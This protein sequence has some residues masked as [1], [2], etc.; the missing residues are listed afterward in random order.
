MRVGTFDW[1]DKDLPVYLKCT[2]K[3][4]S[5]LEHDYITCYEA[6]D[7]AEKHEICVELS[8]HPTYLLSIILNTLR[9]IG[10]L[11]VDYYGSRN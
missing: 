8:P 11:T 7:S 6:F 5:L 4:Q 10:S 2:P 9:K 1:F 3:L